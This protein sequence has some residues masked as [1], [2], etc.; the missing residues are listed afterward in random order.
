[1][2]PKKTLSLG[3]LL[4]LA[5]LGLALVGAGSVDLAPAP[6][7][8][9]LSSY[10]GATCLED[11][12]L[13]KFR[14]AADKYQIGHLLAS[15]EVREIE[16]LPG[17]DVHR[18]KISPKSGLSDKLEA[19][20]GDPMVV[21]A[22]PNYCL[23]LAASVPNDPYFSYQWAFRN[24]GQPLAPP[25]YQIPSGTPGA[26]TRA[27]DAWDI[28]QGSDT[29]IV[30][31]V[32]T[33]VDLTHPDLINH[34]LSPGIDFPNNDYEAQDDHGHGTH[35]AGIIAAE[36][37]N[38]I[39]G[40]G[41]D[42]KAKILPVKVFNKNA[43][44][45]TSWVANGIT[46]AAASGARVINMSL[47]GRDVTVN[48]TLE[49]AIKFAYDHNVVLVAAA[50]N[51]GTAGVWYPAAYD[52]YVLAAA[53]T[54][55]NDR[56]VTLSMTGGTFGSNYGPE[57][58]VAA[59]GLD[60]LSTWPIGLYQRGHPGY[61]GYVYNWGTSSSTA[62]V[63]GLATLIIS[64][65]PELSNEEVMSVIRLSAD[66]VNNA[67]LPGFDEYLGWGRINALRALF[68]AQFMAHKIEIEKGR[69]RVTRAGKR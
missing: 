45:L 43:V 30:G 38:G 48:Q 26:D 53:A 13:V 35:V 18:L 61:P 11:E 55:Q 49:L 58:D 66:D 68:L 59:P 33:G 62:F 46:W 21:Y 47:G 16:T 3:L 10:Q 9:A 6:S 27:A 22:E 14:P 56:C 60:I 7:E 34:I 41:F 8:F 23:H 54:E 37:N 5:G 20:R 15:A 50:G 39:G 51:N 32:D 4:G 1:M 65:R 69:S 36:G 64:S 2:N 28:F 52:N 24:T 44:G 12:I 57:V 29:T 42:W 31:V 40:T 25:S 67:S 63:S 19:L 17:I